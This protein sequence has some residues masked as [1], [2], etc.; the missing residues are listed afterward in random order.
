[1]K[2]NLLLCGFYLKVFKLLLKLLVACC[3]KMCLPFGCV[4]ASNTVD[5]QELC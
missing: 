2:H 4:L 3:W 1:M 5:K